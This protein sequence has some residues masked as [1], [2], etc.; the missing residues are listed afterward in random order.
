MTDRLIMTA[1]LMM[2]AVYFINGFNWFFKIIGPYPSISD[3]AHIAPPPDVVV[4]MI[5]NG[6][7]FHMVKATELLTGIALLS[8][9]FVPLMLV[10][11][12]PVTLPICLVDVF[13]VATPRGFVMGGGSIILNIF[14]L[15]AYFSH[16]RTVL[17]HRGV[18]GFTEP[19]SAPD[20][21]G[22]LAAAISRFVGPI[23]PIFGIVAICF[24]AVM[25][26]WLALLITQYAVHPMSFWEIHRAFAPR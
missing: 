10:A 19:A 22:A 9:R 11:A 8:N 13:F 2:G 1:R 16:Y 18:P 12:L 15:L 4:A 23:F 14:L 20:S 21:E 5:Q 25:L 3:F 26:C 6:M 17:A 7:L 24:G